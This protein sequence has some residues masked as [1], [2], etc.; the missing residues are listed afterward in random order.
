LNDD[1]VVLDLC[2]QISGTAA[3]FGTDGIEVGI[4]KVTVEKL[5]VYPAVDY[6]LDEINFPASGVLDS[7][8]GTITSAGV[9]GQWCPEFTFNVVEGEEC[10]Y[11]MCF[12]GFAVSSGEVTAT[13][14]CHLVKVLNKVAYFDADATDQAEF[15]GLPLEVSTPPLL[16]W[17]CS[18]QNAERWR[19]VVGLCAVQAHGRP[20]LRRLVLPVVRRRL[21]T[22]YCFS[23]RDCTVASRWR[24]A[25]V[26][27]SVGTWPLMLRGECDGGLSV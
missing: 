3:E 12:E 9:G 27:T 4:R 24:R 26:G 11:T 20:L 10:I 25:R 17:T 13:P 22:N 15:V 19:V 16:T 2:L 1:P 6:P 7:D 23:R 18:A 21:G 8:P 14:Q 5:G